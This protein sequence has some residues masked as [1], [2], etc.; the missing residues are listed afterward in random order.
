MQGEGQHPG[1]LTCTGSIQTVKY[2]ELKTREMKEESN[3]PYLLTLLI[4][5][6]MAAK[7]T[8]S[9]LLVCEEKTHLLRKDEL[10]PKGNNSGE[11]FSPN[12]YELSVYQC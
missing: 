7:F 3:T 6:M 8:F 1:A 10:D 2:T 12:Y 9:S 4:P 5:S 11:Q